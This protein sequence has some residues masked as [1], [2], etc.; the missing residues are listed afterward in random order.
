MPIYVLRMVTDEIFE[1]SVEKF[2]QD[3]ATNMLNDKSN[4]AVK[5]KV[6]ESA[7][8]K[9]QEPVDNVNEARAPEVIANTSSDG[10]DSSQGEE[11]AAAPV[12][13][14]AAVA[15]EVV[16]KR[17]TIPTKFRYKRRKYDHSKG[18]E[19]V[20]ITRAAKIEMERLI[21]DAENTKVMIRQRMKSVSE[22]FEVNPTSANIIENATPN[23]FTIS[24][25][26]KESS[27]TK[28]FHKCQ[29]NFV[30]Y[31][32]GRLIE[33]LRQQYPASAAI[34]RER[35]YHVELQ[36]ELLKQDKS[37]RCV[38]F[39]LYES[40]CRRV[41]QI[42]EKTGIYCLFIPEVLPPTTLRRGHLEEFAQLVRYVDKHLS[43]FKDVGKTDS[44]GR[45]LTISDEDPSASA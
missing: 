14:S 19:E 34:Q 16:G 29:E 43:A 6:N 1:N 13:A 38:H 3:T 41:V 27:D 31:R 24:S 32:F 20:Y 7:K 33:N 23:V 26:P 11:E 9:V 37:F 17:L 42:V 28:I 12:H 8:D 25:W 36:K 39:Y 2:S 22:S 18:P 30:A 21:S 15:N 40:F 35:Q 5:D 45:F 4:E 44:N 10:V